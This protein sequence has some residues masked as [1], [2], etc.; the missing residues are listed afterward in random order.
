MPGLSV[1]DTIACLWRRYR[2]R[3]RNYLSAET[4]EDDWFTARDVDERVARWAQVLG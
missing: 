3:G 1:L 2:A 4:H